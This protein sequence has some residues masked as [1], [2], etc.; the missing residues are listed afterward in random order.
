VDGSRSDQFG[1]ADAQRLKA[2]AVH[3]GIALQ[4]ARMYSKTEEQ[5]RQVQQII[6]TVP[7]GVL[8]LDEEKRFILTNPAAQRFLYQLTGAH[9]PDQPLSSLAGYS[10]D[11]I[12]SLY[13]SVPWH[14]ITI[15][16]P[17]K[18]IFEIAAHPLEIG[19]QSPGWVVVLRDVTSEREIQAQ[20]YLQERLVTVGQLAAGISHDFN[21]ILA[22]ILV[23]VDLVCLDPNLSPS[24]QKQLDIIQNQ[25][26]RATGLVRQILDFSRSSAIEQS[27][28]DLYSFIKELEGLLEHILPENIQL[29]LDCS[30]GQYTIR[31]DPMRLQQAFM[32][33]YLNARDAM[34]G[35]G[36]F[37]FRLD[38]FTLEPGERP[39]Y[40]D[41][42]PG[43]WIGI[44]V[45]D[46]GVGI[47]ANV[48]PH[49]F[50]PFFT[51]KP[52]GKG[53]GLGLAQAYGIIKQHGG[54]ID[55]Q[56]Q[57]GEGTTFSIY[58]PALET[59]NG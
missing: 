36:K 7:E 15:E 2:F 46:T 58:F 28:L 20:V 44:R 10:V 47:P 6:D 3:A 17:P 31:A 57:E 29:E 21:N 50:D 34:P 14:E 9:H 1:P 12:L 13:T 33:L 32:N 51:T 35:G 16:G 41:L 25:I 48:L 45:Q 19:T 40:P 22:A 38:R 54:S 26:R 8:L 5:A 42:L 43:E 27:N 39:P 4:N 55:V 37:I 11:D 49:I 53:T 52:V 18:R 56:S 23:Y 59:E 30:P 24:S